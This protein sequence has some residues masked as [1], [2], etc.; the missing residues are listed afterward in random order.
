MQKLLLGYDV[1]SS[2]IKASLIDADGNE[3]MAP[4][5]TPC[6]IP[7]AQETE[8]NPSTAGF[9]RFTAKRL[10]RAASGC[11]VGTCGDSYEKYAFTNFIN[12]I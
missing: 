4:I 10:G 11:L 12:R 5:S 7:P 8:L 3:A 2:S 1:G 9:T 6:A